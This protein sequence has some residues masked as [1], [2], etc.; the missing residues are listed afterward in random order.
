M[1]V[2]MVAIGRRLRRLWPLW[3]VLAALLAVVLVLFLPPLLIA[4]YGLKDSE[5]RLAAENAMRTTLAGTFGG[6]AVIGGA[7]VG[8]L[9]FRETSR[10]NRANS[11]QN[12]AVLELQ[13]RG[14]VTER[15]SK[16]IE[17]L[18]QTGPD[19]LDVRIGAAYALEQIAQDSPNLHWPIMEVLTA[20]LREHARRT[21]TTEADGGSTE[22]RTPAD[23]QAIA[24]V[25]GRRRHEQDPPKQRLDLH[26]VDLSGVELAGAQLKGAYLLKAQLKGAYLGGAQLKGATLVGAQ[27]E[28]AY[29]GGAQLEGAYL[30]GAQLERAYLGEAQLKG[31]YLWKAQL[32]GAYLS[33]AD[34]TDAEN[35]T[36]TQLQAARNWGQAKLP[37]YLIAQRAEQGGP[38]GV[39][40]PRLGAESGEQGSPG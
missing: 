11:E 5:K 14:Q 35:L 26:Q 2:R 37:A 13:R 6:L 1:E 34:L 20:Y 17:Q 16:A 19:K 15:F 9:N 27:L 32:E 40:E 39:D 21:E 25:I 36:W 7:I 28:G 29:L 30:G 22:A 3:V 38:D 18:G 10:Q 33:G 24:T 31:A 12:R 4:P 23:H 8:A